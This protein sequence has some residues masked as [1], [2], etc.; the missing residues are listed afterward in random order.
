[1]PENPNRH[2]LRSEVAQRLTRLSEE[3]RSRLVEI[4]LI[5][6]RASGT[7]LPNSASVKFA[8]RPLAKDANAAAG[9][10]MEIIEVAADDG[11]TYTAC[12]GVIDGQP[13]AESPCGG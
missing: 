7:D 9:D 5:T 3:V 13:F 12:Y 11:Q 10:W 4:A 1:M 8:P 6:A 2:E